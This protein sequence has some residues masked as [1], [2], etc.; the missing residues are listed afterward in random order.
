VSFQLHE[1]PA[2][3]QFRRFACG[4]IICAEPEEFL[5]VRVKVALSLE[6]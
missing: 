4:M 2:A 5:K 1:D 3:Q 6:R